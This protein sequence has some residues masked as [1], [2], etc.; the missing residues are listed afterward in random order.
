MVISFIL[1]INLIISLLSD[2][3]WN[4]AMKFYTENK[5]LVFNKKHFIFD[6]CN[7]TKLSIN[8]TKMKTL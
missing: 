1:L 4:K 6:E 7:Y 5:M 2:E 8:D 3:I